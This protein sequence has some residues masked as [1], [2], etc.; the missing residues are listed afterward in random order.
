MAR[1]NEY[2][3]DGSEYEK[4]SDALS[5]IDELLEDVKRANEEKESIPGE[6]RGFRSVIAELQTEL[7]ACIGELRKSYSELD[8]NPLYIY[9]TEAISLTA[10]TRHIKFLHPDYQHVWLTEGKGENV[11]SGLIPFIDYSL[12]YHYD[13][14]RV[15]VTNLVLSPKLNLPGLKT[16]L[17][18]AHMD[19][20][21]LKQDAK[22]V[23]MVD[24]N[25]AA[26][27]EKLTETLKNYC[28][29]HDI[30]FAIDKE[31]VPFMESTE[32]R[33]ERK[34]RELE[35]AKRAEQE[36]QKRAEEARAERIR[37][38][39]ERAA[40]RRAEEEAEASRRKAE[41][42]RAEQK[43]AEE[44]RARKKAQEERAARK[45]AEE[46]R[47]ARKRAQ[48][49]RAV[50]KRAEEARAA[51]IRE[52]EAMVAKVRADE[53]ARIKMQESLRK[54]APPWPSKFDS[55]PPP[56]PPVATRSPLPVP[57][58]PPLVKRNS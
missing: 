40:V 42:E 41:K 23:E 35:E 56:L 27:Q 3:T 26:A 9:T 12:E 53:E 33:A 58:P 36:A 54:S 15:A 52:E 8:L 38:E 18:A 57:L 1:T 46:E 50:R 55:A 17:E 45:R 51:R 22:R 29:S 13:A 7:D 32:E 28:E 49:E 6:Q 21:I 24:E 39:E 43:K 31:N 19:L 16:S 14:Q 25:G 44:E 48:E 2:K 11:A 34:K 37:E 5:S 47:T 10:Y 30:E 4:L 20:K